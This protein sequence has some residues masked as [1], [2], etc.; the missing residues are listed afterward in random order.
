MQLMHAAFQSQHADAVVITDLANHRVDQ[1]GANEATCTNQSGWGGSRVTPSWI[2]FIP[3]DLDICGSSENLFEGNLVEH[4][5]YECDDSGAFNTCGQVPAAC[6]HLR[7]P[8][9]FSPS[10]SGSCPL[11]SAAFA[12]AC[13]L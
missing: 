6:Y 1:G 3:D 10:G 12:C 5:V 11:A 2:K 4:A 8:V 7:V 13:I 9:R